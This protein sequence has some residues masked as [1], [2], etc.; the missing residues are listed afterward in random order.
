MARKYNHL[1][2]E[3]RIVIRVR[4]KAGESIR[5]ISRELGRAPSTVSRELRRNEQFTNTRVIYPIYA[6]M[7]ANGR[8]RRSYRKPRL[9]TRKLQRHVIKKLQAGWSPLVIAGRLK[10]LQREETV[11]HE[12]IYQF[13]YECRPDLRACLARHHKRRKRFRQSK[14]FSGKP[15][16]PFRISINDRPESVAARTAV[17]DW[18]GDLMVSKAGPEAVQVLLER[19][20]R[21]V[22]LSKIEN[23]TAKV[24]RKAIIKKLKRVPAKYR[25]T[26]TYDNGKENVEHHLVNKALGTQSYFADT[27]ASWQK[28]SVE[29]VIGLVRRQYPKKTDI[30][31]ISLQE[32]SLLER[33]LNSTP[34]KSLQFR[35]PMEVFRD[36][37]VALQC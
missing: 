17:G 28:G 26:I 32:L 2:Y 3:D 10:C 14:K 1:S 33:R 5:K 11:S 4:K 12:A 9:K 36:R 34:R 35:T 8:R 25:K 30:G 6:Q 21:R 13:I 23:K 19:K 22:F 29:N 15:L 37:S 20:S 27:Y 18:E 31:N 7:K 16:I 24:V